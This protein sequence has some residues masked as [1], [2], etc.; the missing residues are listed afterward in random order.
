MAL[1]VKRALSVPRHGTRS[2]KVAIGEAQ[3]CNR[4]AQAFG[5]RECS[6]LLTKSGTAKSEQTTFF[7]RISHY[8]W[9]LWTDSAGLL[10][11]E[12]PDTT[13]RGLFFKLQKAGDHIEMYHDGVKLP[14]GQFSTVSNA[15][16]IKTTDEEIFTGSCKTN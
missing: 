16:F 1:A 9:W 15:L 6:G 3:S 10:H 8:G 2:S 14:Q 13:T 7:I 4:T 12:I 5:V 11:Y